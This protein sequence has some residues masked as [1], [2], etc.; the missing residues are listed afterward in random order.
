MLKIISLIFFLFITAVGFT[1][2]K[3]QRIKGGMLFTENNHRILFYQVEPKSR[4]GEYERCNYIHPIWAND[5]TVL[6]E[7]FPADHLHHRG[8]FWAWHQIW[9]DGKR[10]GD[11]WEIK[12]FKQQVSEVEYVREKDGSAKLNTE[13]FWKSDLWQKDGKEVPY[14]KENTTI[15]IHPLNDDYRKIDFEIRLLAL[16]ENLEIGGSEDEKGYSGFSIRMVLPDDVSF[17]GINGKVEPQNIAV[18]SPGF[19]TISGTLNGNNRKTGIV[20][21]DNPYNPEYPQPWILRAKESMQ[22]AAFP[23]NK[24]ISV[25][26]SSPLVLKYSLIVYSG[27][28]SNKKIENIVKQ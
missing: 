17:S 9:I 11:G 19:I 5:G 23:G 10:I 12:N 24:R 26:T 15:I 2:V 8:V 25:P 1:Q 27:N 18:Q 16:E 6:T 20:M 28:L 13:V 7:D 4:D 21:V 22:N 3:M 14:L